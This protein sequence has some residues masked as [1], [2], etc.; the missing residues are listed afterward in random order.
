[1]KLSTQGEQ[2]EQSSRLLLHR[3]VVH[4]GDTHCRNN[5]I[6]FEVRSVVG[7]G[8]Y[9]IEGK[10]DRQVNDMRVVE[11]HIGRGLEHG[12]RY[13]HVGKQRDLYCTFNSSWWLLLATGQR[14]AIEYCSGGCCHYGLGCVRVQCPDGMDRTPYGVFQILR[15]FVKGG[16]LLSLLRALR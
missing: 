12:R 6:F 16:W 4:R 14:W 7:L 5:F 2:V 3:G 8:S 9:V 1:M 13:R 11:G 15:N 10:T